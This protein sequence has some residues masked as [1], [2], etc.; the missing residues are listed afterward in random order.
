MVSCIIAT[1]PAT[2]QTDPCTSCDEASQNQQVSLFSFFFFGVVFKTIPKK[3]KIQLDVP[4]EF[5]NIQLWEAI[6]YIQ[7]VLLI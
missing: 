6:P 2:R 5:W 4:A 3:H 7:A 1:S